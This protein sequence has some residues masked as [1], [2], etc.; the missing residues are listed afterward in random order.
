MPFSPGKGSVQGDRSRVSQDDSHCTRLAQHDMVLGP[1]QP[2]EPNSINSSATGGSGDS[3]F[4][5]GLPP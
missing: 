5:R 2:V 4:H 3:A 1:G